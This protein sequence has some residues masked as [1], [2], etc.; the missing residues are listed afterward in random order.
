M[1]IENELKQRG[2]N[3]VKKHGNVE[4]DKAIKLL[5]KQWSAFIQ[6]EVK[7]TADEEKSFMDD[8]ESAKI[9]K[10]FNNALENNA[11]VWVWKHLINHFK[12]AK[13]NCMAWEIELKYKQDVFYRGTEDFYGDN[14]N[15]WY[16]SILGE[17]SVNFFPNT[18]NGKLM[19][20]WTSKQDG[21]KL[22]AQIN[23]G[24]TDVILP[25]FVKEV[26]ELDIDADAA[27]QGTG[28]KKKRK[29]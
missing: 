12:A 21:K 27:K 26:L 18:I 3:I 19:K 7:Y 6:K 11:Q 23:L 28:K 14:F 15:I 10:I 2:I 22:N 25:E 17:Y 9:L 1:G 13:N 29:R 16:P 24:F 8:F 20:L 5:F 4:N